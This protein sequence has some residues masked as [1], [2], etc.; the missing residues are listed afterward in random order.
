MSGQGAGPGF[1]AY[2]LTMGPIMLLVVG[3]MKY[4]VNGVT[5]GAVKM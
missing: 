3:T 2:I 1:A 4:F 5:S